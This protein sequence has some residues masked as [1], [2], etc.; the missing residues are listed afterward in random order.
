MTDAK[1]NLGQVIKISYAAELQ[2]IAN[3]NINKSNMLT[4][5]VP[6][7]FREKQSFVWLVQHNFIAS[8]QFTKHN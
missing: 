7:F 1:D 8:E 5:N 2:K 4:Q 3:G 6:Q